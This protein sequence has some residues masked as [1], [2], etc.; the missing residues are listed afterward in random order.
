MNPLYLA[1]ECF[2]KLPKELRLEPWKVTEHGR[3]ILQTEDELNAYMAAY[4]EMH[5]V[6]C[7]AALQN[8]PFENLLHYSFEIF[9]W[10]CEQNGNVCGKR[11]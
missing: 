11:Q 2:N 1:E 7:R 9:D 3:K 5:S 8:F 6:K 10:G 4:G